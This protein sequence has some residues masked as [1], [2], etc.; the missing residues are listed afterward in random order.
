[1]L[2]KSFR[3]T[4]LA[5]KTVFDGGLVSTVEEPKRIR[6]ILIDVDSYHGNSVEGWIE[7][8]RILEIPD[9]CCSTSDYLI[10]ASYFRPTVKMNRIP[11]EEVIKPGM[12]FKIA[13]NC[14]AA[15]TNIRGSYEYEPST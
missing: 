9:E 3:I 4:G 13:I 2:Y 6:A 8:T 7:T 1:M 5:N 12:T 11:I 15:T 10:G 14:G